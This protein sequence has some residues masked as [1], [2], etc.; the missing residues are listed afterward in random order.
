MAQWT[1]LFLS[2]C[3]AL[4]PLASAQ[5]QRGGPWRHRIQWE[6]NG[7][8][9][10]LMSTGSQYQAPGRYRGPSRL[11]MSSNGHH[12]GLHRPASLHRPAQYAAPFQ[13]APVTARA[14]G[15][16]LTE[17][18][19]R[20]GTTGHQGT[21][22]F[23]AVNASAAAVTETG[24]ARTNVDSS[25]QHTRSEPVTRSQSQSLRT[26]PEPLT[27]TQNQP[28]RT[29]PEP[30]TRTQNQ[31]LRTVPESLARAQTQPLRTGPELALVSRERAQTDESIPGPV[32]VLERDPEVPVSFAAINEDTTNDVNTNAVDVVN[33]DPR[34][35]FKNHRNS[36]L[37]NLYPNRARPAARPQRPPPGTGYGTRLFQNGLP[38]LVPDPYA[39]QAGTYVQ[40]TQ[41]YALRCAAEEN[42]LAR[43]AYSPTVRDIDFRVLL[44]F[45]QKV[46]N[47]GT[48]DFLP[49]KPRYQWDWH[50]CHQHYH[51][52]EAFSNYDLLDSVTGRK[53]AE[54]HKASFCLEDTSCEP[55][56]RRRY[57]CTAH[58]QGLSPGCHDIYA[59][60]IDCQWIDITDVPPGNYV[61]KITVNP[62]FH[63]LESDFTNNIVRCDITYTGVYAQ[64]R[65]C[66]ITRS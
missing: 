55:G 52:M 5:A 61:L 54:G 50:S 45:P 15:A 51:S 19:L 2:F 29:V 17:R 44:R 35:P 30:L 28:L 32:P 14:S 24:L 39:I 20:A 16:R 64:T 66:R 25:S 8:V 46:R 42:C 26:V 10:S 48:A 23:T 7:Q 34:N 6:N 56:F 60:N 31:P 33:D 9:Y 53:V 58:T 41:M 11:Y 40:R 57:A 22:Q 62:N 65:N 12:P 37:Y 18:P 21:P 36:V 49:V 59:A 63:V 4:A 1:L 43:S 47:Q 38:D 27:R 3:Q 13:Y